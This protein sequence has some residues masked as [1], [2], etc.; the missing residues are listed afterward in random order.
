MDRVIRM[1]PILVMAGT[2]IA[3]GAVGQFQLQAAGKEIGE[4]EEAVEENEDDIEGIQ[5]RLIER[6]GAI[7]L[8]LERLRI[9]QKQQSDKLD[10]VL[11]LLQAPLARP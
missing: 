7:S 6:Q 10:R 3:Y 9:Q 8:D 1:W 5:R 4:L 2:M 11:D